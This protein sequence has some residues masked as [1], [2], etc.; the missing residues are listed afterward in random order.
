[1]TDTTVAAATP[2]VVPSKYLTR[3]E[4]EALIAKCG[5]TFLSQTGFLKVEAAKGRRLYIASTKTV[6]RIDIS[7][8]EVAEDLGQTPHCGVFGQVKQQVILTGT[9]DEQLARLEAVIEVMKT[10]PAVEKAP[11]PAKAPKAPKSAGGTATGDAAPKTEAEVQAGT[12]S[13]MEMIKK[14]AA[15]RGLAI[16]Q[17]TLALADEAPAAEE[18]EEVLGEADDLGV[19]LDGDNEEAEVADSLNDEPAPGEELDFS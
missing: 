2:V 4:V 18:I 13:R 11:K 5:L 19:N 17:K 8:F 16:S 15:E 1:M 10:L 9:V 12:L 3:T 6:R 7:G 14:Y